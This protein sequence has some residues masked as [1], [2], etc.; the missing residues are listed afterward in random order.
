MPSASRLGDRID[1]LQPNPHVLHPFV[2]FGALLRL[3]ITKR[4]AD[5]AD[6]HRA[7]AI[8]ALRAALMALTREGFASASG[9]AAAEVHV[10]LGLEQPSTAHRQ[11]RLSAAE[12]F[13]PPAPFFTISSALHAR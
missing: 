9:A 4:D 2:N 8:P 11:V 13:M 5:V 10:F 3:G 1:A 6:R 7:S 12:S